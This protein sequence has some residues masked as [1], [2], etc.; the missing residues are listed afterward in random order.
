MFLSERT[1][2]YVYR[3]ALA[4]A[5]LATGYGWVTDA[6]AALWI[7]VIAAILGNGLATR[8]TSTDR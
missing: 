7:P 8:H 6:Q 3:I 5:V 4:A 1:R 2:A